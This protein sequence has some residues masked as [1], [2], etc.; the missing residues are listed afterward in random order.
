MVP[1]INS[2]LSQ[3]GGGIIVAILF[4]IFHVSY[5]SLVKRGENKENEERKSELQKNIEEIKGEIS[6]NT[7]THKIITGRSLDREI[8]YN[9]K[10]YEGLS[11][12]WLNMRSAF[13]L[14][15]KIANEPSMLPN[16]N[17]YDEHQL[18]SYLNTLNISDDDKKII[19]HSSKKSAELFYIL[20]HMNIEK[21]KNTSNDFL[22]S[23]Y[24]YQIFIEDDIY[25][26]FYDLFRILDAIIVWKRQIYNQYCSEETKEEARSNIKAHLGEGAKKK[27]SVLLEEIKEKIKK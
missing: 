12:C 11:E 26:K 13:E 3:S 24:K 7:E 19:Q 21:I 16:V 4:A 27:M 18:E 15:N 20:L 9:Q 2:L 17:A 6:K 5:T 8:K 10:E 1:T 25:E 22:N 14:A 23:L